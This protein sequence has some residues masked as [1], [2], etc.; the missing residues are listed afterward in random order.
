MVMTK[1]NMYTWHL[2]VVRKS[3]DNLSYSWL[4]PALALLTLATKTS[5]LHPFTS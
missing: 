3:H 2:L 4:S 5:L 1:F